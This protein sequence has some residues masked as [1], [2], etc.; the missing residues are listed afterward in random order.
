M[1]Q[2]HF[3]AGLPRAGSTLLAALLSQNPRL[4]ARMTSPVG[5]MVSAMLKSMSAENEG[6]VFIDDAARERVLRG[7]V[8]NYY[9]AAPQPLVFDTNRLW[10][11]RLALI[12]RLFPA[13]RVIVC[14]RNPAWVIDSIESLVRQNPLLPSG[15]F[16]HDPGGT[17]Y[18]RVEGLV[19]A[20]GMVG[21]AMNGIREAVFS[22]ERQ[23]LLL[24]RYESLVADPRRALAAIYDAIG[25]APFDHDLEAIPQDEQALAFDARLGTPGLHRVAPRLAAR[26]RPTLLPPDLF[27]THSKTGFWDNIGGL[28]KD[29]KIV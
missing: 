5:S 29:V 11:T 25:E 26:S 19:A 8:E 24:L 3:I 23:R 6:A 15:I 21:F 2:F 16:G 7:I 4:S 17:V 14:V 13:A 1:P 18:S 10:T 12:A 27:Q 20:A 9:A 22:A 28:P